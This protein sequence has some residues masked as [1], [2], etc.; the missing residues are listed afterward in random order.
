MA[1]TKKAA[2]GHT[3]VTYVGPHNEVEVGVLRGQRFQYGV[4][5]EVPTEIAE[6]L[7]EQADWSR[8]ADAKIVSKHRA[9]TRAVTA[10]EY[11]DD[12]DSGPIYRAQQN[13]PDEQV[14]AQYVEPDLDSGDPNP[15]PEAPD[16]EVLP[17]DEKD[18]S[19]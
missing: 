12:P 3:A 7:L 15:S 11:N 8:S 19:A 5:A 9:S 14:P 18:G 6:R 13:D 17:N 10:A 4:R 16:Y 1:G 2:P